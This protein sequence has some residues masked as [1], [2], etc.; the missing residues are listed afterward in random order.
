MR[1]LF[2]GLVKVQLARCSVA[3][4]AQG[5][6]IHIALGKTKEIHAHLHRCRHSNVHVR[7]CKSDIIDRSSM[8][9]IQIALVAQTS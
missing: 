4:Y 1:V 6:N 9:N 7:Y 2:E 8:T 5:C 3:Q